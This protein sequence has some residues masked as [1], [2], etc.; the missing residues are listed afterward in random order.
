M[1][2]CFPLS[3]LG[4]GPKSGQFEKQFAKISNKKYNI[5]TNSAGTAAF[6]IFDYLYYLYGLCNVFV[7]SLSFT[8]PAW[9]AKQVGHN[10]V[11]VDVNS[12]LMFDF[13]S[14]KSYGADK[15]NILMPMLYGG[16]SDIFPWNVTDEIVVTDCAHALECKLPSDFMF[17]SFHSQKCIKMSTGGVICTDDADAAAY[18]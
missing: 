8:S 18:L 5:A 14:Y 9:A 6:M 12:Y 15:R 13:L 1:I 2:T 3:K 11:F 4:F 7:P 16:A 10:L 17:Y